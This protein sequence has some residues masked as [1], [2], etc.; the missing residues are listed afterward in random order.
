MYA[1]HFI[2]MFFSLILMAIVGVGF[3]AAVNHYNHRD[4]LAGITS[5][6]TAGTSTTT[7]TSK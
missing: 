3:L 7:K 6:V 5:S 1:K 4:L 2:T